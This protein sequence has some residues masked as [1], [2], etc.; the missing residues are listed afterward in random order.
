MATNIN[1]PP[2]FNASDVYKSDD[3]G[4]YMRF[5]QESEDETKAPIDLL[6]LTPI[7]YQVQ[8]YANQAVIEKVIPEGRLSGSGI[9]IQGEDNDELAILVEESEAENIKPIIH[10]HE[11]IYSLAD[12]TT[13]TQWIGDV[14]FKDLFS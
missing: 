12:G 9:Y 10:R 14:P 6:E 2:I 1:F 5:E 3:F 11:L 13:N 7:I 8:E 4:F